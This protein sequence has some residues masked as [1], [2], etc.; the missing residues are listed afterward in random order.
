MTDCQTK[1]QVIRNNNNRGCNKKR[2]EPPLAWSK[3]MIEGRLF[4]EE[5]VT[6]NTRFTSRMNGEL[7]GIMMVLGIFT[8]LLMLPTLTSL[9][10]CN[11]SHCWPK[12]IA[13]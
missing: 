4:W 11:R 8:S 5:F 3:S 2:N 10:F 9:I 13:E 1:R 7:G 12:Y 6:S